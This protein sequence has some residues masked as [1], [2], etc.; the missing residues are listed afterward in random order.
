M[1]PYK[2]LTKRIVSPDGK[3]IAEANSIVEASGDREGE[4]N[5]S[6]AVQVSSRNSSISYAKSSSIN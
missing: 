6:V 1:T 3:V 2:F 4:I 5:Q